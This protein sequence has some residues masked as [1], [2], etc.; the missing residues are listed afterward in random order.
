VRWVIN[1]REGGNLRTNKGCWYISYRFLHALRFLP[2]PYI[3][4][5]PTPRLEDLYAFSSIL[6]FTLQGVVL[7]L[8]RERKSD[9][10]KEQWREIDNIFF[11]ARQCI[12]EAEAQER[13]AK[14]ALELLPLSLRLEVGDSRFIS[15][16]TYY[17][18][19]PHIGS[20]QP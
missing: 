17:L 9:P 12:K 7:I 19:E 6:I 14:W 8:R 16:A 11:V 2:R 20:F 13:K 1:G 18:H 3:F 5:N 15:L 10:I 4:N